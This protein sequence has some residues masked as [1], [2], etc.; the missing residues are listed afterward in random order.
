[1]ET[2]FIDFKQLKCFLDEKTEQYNRPEFVESDPIQVPKAFSR[3][4]DI[5]IAGFL[6]ST[7]AW[8]QR[9]TIVKNAQKMM[10]LLGNSPYDFVMS[11]KKSDLIRLE[12]FVHR[13]FNGQDFIEFIHSLRRIY[14]RFGSLE[15]AVFQSV[16]NKNLQKGI[17]NFKK[18]FFEETTLK[19]TEKHLSD[20]EKG[21][22]AKRINM[23][24]RWMVR[25][26]NK[27]VDLGLWKKISPS[28]L[29]CPLDVHSA[30]VGRLLGLITRKQNDAKALTQLDENLR[31]FDSNDP[32]KYDFALFGLGI[33]ENWK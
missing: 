30:N 25:S 21:S 4:E 33:F 28:Q 14:K 8:G 12:S 27:G 1:M 10:N 7:I 29:S 5:E 15:E 6:A 11:H 31:K 16:E 19:R 23:Y 9:K 24:F 2:K 13:T 20:P 3:T 17:S 22:A 18:L 26:D 32:A